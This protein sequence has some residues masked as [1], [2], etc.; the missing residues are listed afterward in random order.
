[1][2]VLKFDEKDGFDWLMEEMRAIHDESGVEIMICIYKKRDG[3]VGIGTTR[4]NNAEILGL[5]EFGK[6]EYIESFYEE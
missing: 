1:M 4:G 3:R 5:I 2:K 6:T